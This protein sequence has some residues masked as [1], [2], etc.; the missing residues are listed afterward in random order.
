MKRTIFTKVTCCIVGLVL[1]THLISQNTV[2]GI[3]SSESGEPLIGANVLVKGTT[4]GSTSEFDGSYELTTTESFP[5][6][7][8]FSFTGYNTTEMQINSSLT[9]VNVQLDEGILLGQDVVVSASRKREKIQEAPASVSVLTARTLESSPQVDPTRNLMNLA[10]IHVQQQSA[11]RINIQMRGD[12]GVFG[13][14]SFPI[15]DYRSLIGPGIGT[16]QTELAGVSNIDLEIIEVVRGAG[17]A[18]Y[19]PGVTAGVVHYI[20]KSPIDFPGTSV[21]VYGGEMNTFG[22]ALRQ[23]G[24]NSNKTF[25]YKLNVQYNRG[26]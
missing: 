9:N 21:Q 8:V 1:S 22:A 20:T 10:G 17:S 23:A 4:D 14:A 2:S 6:T 5:L 26:D 12:G 11:H 25:G 15:K 13:S 3:I 19:G 7:L 18:L 16:F 24:T